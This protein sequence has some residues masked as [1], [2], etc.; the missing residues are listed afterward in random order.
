MDE[1]KPTQWR[2]LG[3]SLPPAPGNDD[4]HVW[5][6]SL[7][8]DV[9]TISRLA[10]ILSA[11]ESQR[12]GSY[13]FAEHRSRFIA[14]RAQLRVLL[15]NYL[16][17]RPGELRFRYDGHGKPALHDSLLDRCTFNVTHSGDLALFAVACNREVGID[18]ELLRPNLDAQ[19]LAEH[20]FTAQE[21]SALRDVPE[22][23]KLEVFGRCWTRKEAYLKGRG[24]GLTRSLNSVQVSCLQLEPGRLLALEDSVAPNEGWTLTSLEPGP[25]YA[26]ALA[27]KGSGWRLSCFQ[28]PVP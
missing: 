17:M 19:E 5:R 14:A 26:A 9:I 28:M 16:G 23:Q 11:D 22:E 13:R 15:G 1:A 20:Y 25:G 7:D 3:G 4:V 21:V 2:T 12:A 6:A 18:M 24:E 8:F 27:V 10:Q